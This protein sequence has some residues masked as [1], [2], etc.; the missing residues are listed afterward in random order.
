M[1]GSLGNATQF[2]ICLQFGKDNYA[3]TLSIDRSRVSCLACLDGFLSIKRNLACEQALLFGPAKRAARERASER[4][5]R[6]GPTPRPSQ[7]RLLS[8]ASRACTFHD[9]PRMESLLAG[10]AESVLSFWMKSCRNKNDN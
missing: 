10:Q 8:R 3:T 1:L 2:G 5:S 7:S 6:D 4:R 9:I